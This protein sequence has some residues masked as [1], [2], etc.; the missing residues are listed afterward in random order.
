METKNNNHNNCKCNGDDNSYNNDNYNI[1][2]S[3]IIKGGQNKFYCHT[4]TTGA[5]LAGGLA[6]VE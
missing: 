2:G 4:C 1:N 5:Y 3:G 6:K